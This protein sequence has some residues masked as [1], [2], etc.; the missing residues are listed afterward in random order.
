MLQP[1]LSWALLFSTAMVCF[2]LAILVRRTG[3]IPG[4]RWLAYL[5]ATASFY[6]LVSGLEAVI[7][8][9]SAKI[10]LSTLEHVA[11]NTLGPLFVLF[12]WAF[13]RADPPLGGGVRVGLWVVP[14]INVA[15]TAT[16]SLHGLVWAGFSPGPPGTGALIYH[17]GP[18]F[19]VVLAWVYGC[20]LAAAWRMVCWA[21]RVPPAQRPKAWVLLAAMAIPLVGSVLY[22][23]RVLPGSGVNL[24]PMAFAGTAIILAWSLLPSRPFE[25]VPA[26]RTALLEAIPDGVLVVDDA[27]R[28]V[29]V[30]PAAQHLLAL[31]DD[32]AGATSEEVFGRWPQ[33]AAVVRRGEVE[34]VQVALGGANE[35][36]LEVRVLPLAGRRGRFAGRLVLLRDITERVQAE[37]E[38]RDSEREYRDLV[39]PAVVGVYR[40]SLE[41]ELLYVNDAMWRMFGYSSAA[42][43]RE[44]GAVALYKDHADRVALMELLRRD[45]QVSNFEFDAVDARGETRRVLVS[46]RL[47][48]GGVT[49]MVM[50]VTD[51]RQ[52]EQALR[53]SEERFRLL[54][55]RLADA[56]F[57]TTYDG[58]ILEANEAACRQTG[59]SHEE[60]LE[61]NIMHDVACEVPAMYYEQIIARLAQ[62]ETVSFEE[63]KRRKDGSSYW[64]DCALSPIE[65]GGTPLILSVNRDITDRKRAEERLRYLSTHDPLTGAYNRA[66]F[67]EEKARLSRGR[68]FP[69]SLFIADVNGLK[70]ANDED[71]HAAGDA[72]LRR[73]YGVLQAAVRAED[74]VA[75]IGGD[76]FAGLLPETDEAAGLRLLDRIREL[77][78]TDNRQH[79]GRPLSI[80]LGVATVMP[81]E[82]LDKALRLADANMYKDK[83][84]NGT[85]GHRKPPNAT[86]SP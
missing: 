27:K 30:N 38:L 2:V 65:Q 48:E 46:G 59:Y 52:A 6:T 31:S 39:D 9:P 71:G 29:S 15:M 66:Y 24:T 33:L 74:V 60:L 85:H 32:A 84:I 70:V 86:A 51:R 8:V 80:A 36:A 34:P 82:S 55:Q 57:I 37:Q 22:V 63:R 40:S 53:E 3:T 12:V 54:F 69:V 61:L 68:R 73:A 28:V 7:A 10:A 64:A 1:V 72:L 50:D 41:G 16:N 42:A 83:G 23:L 25:L 13:T 11:I 43:C 49:G 44:A 47:S 78:D 81:E 14:V 18:L 79:G 45:G 5:L 17:Y 58:R 67:E 76:E 56:V 75:R 21:R 4:A 62:G 35:T 77:V 20:L 26:A 19:Y